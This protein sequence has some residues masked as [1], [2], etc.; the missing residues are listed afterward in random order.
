MLLPVFA[1]PR[2]HWRFLAQFAE[3]KFWMCLSIVLPMWLVNMVNN[4]AN[5]EAAAS[6]GEHYDQRTC[7]L[8]CALIDLSCAL[9]G[10]PFPSCVY[11]GHASFKAMGCRVGYLLMNILPTIYFGCMRGASLLQRTIPIESGVGFLMWVG[12]Q[13]TAQGFEGDNTPEGW[14]HGPAVAMGLVPSISA[15]SWQTVSTT[16]VAT[17][18]VFCDAMDAKTRAESPTC[19]LELYQMMQEPSTP[20][21]DEHSAL[22]I[23]QRNL[24]SLYLSGM[25]ALA[26]GYLLTAISLSSMLVHVIDGAFDKGAMWLVLLACA[27]SVGLIHSRL[28]DPLQANQ[29]FPAM[30]LLA[31]LALYLCH[32]SQNRSEQL[33]ELQL[34]WA[35]WLIH[36]AESVPPAVRSYWLVEMLVV[37]RIEDMGVGLGLLKRDEVSGRVI[38]RDPSH[39]SLDPSRRE[40]HDDDDDDPSGA[41]Q[42]AGAEGGGSPMAEGSFKCSSLSSFFREAPPDW[43]TNESNAPSPTPSRQKSPTGNATPLGGGSPQLRPVGDS[44]AEPLLRNA[45]PV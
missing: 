43:L 2:L 10:N 40:E 37:D 20:M 41:L 27:S 13:I 45:H 39:H 18:K 36:T 14:R 38:P 29:L 6:L 28:L 16:F 17:Q 15:W 24:S 11:I 44:K 21:A 23:F 32:L 8:G 5:V 19:D 30:Y 1:L 31:A 33:R 4:L 26:N 9:L 22:G 7:L 42:E 3:P 35:T 25:F 12:L 34:R